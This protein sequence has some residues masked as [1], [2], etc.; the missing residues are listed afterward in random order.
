MARYTAIAARYGLL[1]TGGSD[2]HGDDTGRVYR[3]GDVGT[4]PDAFAR[5][6]AR[7][8]AVSGRG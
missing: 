3:I 6:T 5:L 8:A 1:T 4:P 7:L 2:F